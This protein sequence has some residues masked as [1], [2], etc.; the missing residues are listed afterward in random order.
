MSYIRPHIKYEQDIV[1]FK[2]YYFL[3]KIEWVS[4]L[5]QYMAIV[6][7]GVFKFIGAQFVFLCAFIA[8][9]LVV[10]IVF[11]IPSWPMWRSKYAKKPGNRK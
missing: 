10:Y 8:V 9:K 6:A 11:K 2:K 4:I 1:D 7:L 5:P 3:Y